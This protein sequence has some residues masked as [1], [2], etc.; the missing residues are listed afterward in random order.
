MELRAFAYADATRKETKCYNLEELY[1]TNEITL[2]SYIK[3]L[4]AKITDLETKT[5]DNSSKI[6]STNDFSVNVA[7][8][9]NKTLKSVVEDISAIRINI[10][11]LNKKGKV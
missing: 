5:A 6:G 2:G 11:N 4:N 3:S 8:N 9:I 10:S 7:E 1:L